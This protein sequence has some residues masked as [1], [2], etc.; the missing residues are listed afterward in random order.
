M[1]RAPHV[2]CSIVL[3]AMG[4]SN[5]SGSLNELSLHSVIKNIVWLCMKEAPCRDH[6][7]H[8]WIPSVTGCELARFEVC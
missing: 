3:P 4:W 6:P 2:W 5:F 1:V 7:A 8:Y